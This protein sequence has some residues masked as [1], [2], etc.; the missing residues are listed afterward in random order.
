MITDSN[1]FEMKLVRCEWLVLVIAVD[2]Y[3]KKDNV[4]T[5][6]GSFPT[7]VKARAALPELA[8][9]HKYVKGRWIPKA[10]DFPGLNLEYTE[11]RI[12][13]NETQIG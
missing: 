8:T 3:G 10:E 13:Y 2:Q 5:I 12:E 9:E 11:V 4:L 6:L 7:S 1:G